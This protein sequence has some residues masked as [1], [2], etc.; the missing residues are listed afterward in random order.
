MVKAA[1]RGPFPL[2]V[3][4]HSPFA[5]SHFPLTHS[6]SIPFSLSH[7]R[8]TQNQIKQASCLWNGMSMQAM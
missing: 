5:L 7:R 8:S 4:F 1:G 3:L 6:E 2:P